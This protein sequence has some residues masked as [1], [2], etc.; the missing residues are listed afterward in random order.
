MRLA[1]ARHIG[2]PHLRCHHDII[3]VFFLKASD[4]HQNNKYIVPAQL[5]SPPKNIN[6]SLRI[7]IFLTRFLLGYMLRDTTRT[8]TK[9]FV[10]ELGISIVVPER[11][12]QTA[13]AVGL[14]AVPTGDGKSVAKNRRRKRRP[15][16]SPSPN[17]YGKY[18]HCRTATELLSIAELLR[19]LC[20]SPNSYGS[21]V[22]E[23]L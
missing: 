16:M 22:A 2:S 11:Q 3:N 8:A 18:S 14:L 19:N 17:G 12:R 5:L 10:V 13:V 15:K 9:N 7:L 23:R 20:P 6:L 4:F 1:Y 21:S